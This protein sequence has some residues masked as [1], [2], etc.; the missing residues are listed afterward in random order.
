M[1]QAIPIRKR[2]GRMRNLSDESSYLQASFN[3]LQRYIEGAQSRRSR[4]TASM[5]PSGLQHGIT[6]SSY[7]G[8]SSTSKACSSTRI[9]A[10]GQ[11]RRA[12]SAMR[13]ASRL[14]EPIAR[15]T[16]RTLLSGGSPTISEYIPRAV[17]GWSRELRSNLRDSRSS[18]S[19]SS[20]TTAERLRGFVPL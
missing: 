2:F 8:S 18:E 20:K 17:T 14:S 9:L 1:M 19:A 3:K 15:T 4:R 12:C 10:C 6:D 5:T 11:V 7:M 16:R 13:A